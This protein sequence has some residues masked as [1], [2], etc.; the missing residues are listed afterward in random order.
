MNVR[1]RG[2]LTPQK[3]TGFSSGFE[4]AI[5][6]RD[7]RDESAP[8]GVCAPRPL[9]QRRG[10][11]AEPAASGSAPRDGPAGG[12]GRPRA[13][14]PDGA[15]SPGGLRGAGGPDPGARA[16]DPA[17]LAADAAL[18]RAPPRAGA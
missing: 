5:L 11:H 4:A 18:P 3:R 16:R 12:P 8:P 14:L 6:A 17:A 2:F 7:D 9:V 10:R 15:H 13:A 1:P